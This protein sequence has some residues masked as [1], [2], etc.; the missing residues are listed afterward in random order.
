LVLLF[1]ALPGTAGE[2]VLRPADGTEVTVLLQDFAADGLSATEAAGGREVRLKLEDIMSIEFKGAKAPD[3][4]GCALLR[5]AAG[6]VIPARISVGEGGRLSASS[7]WCGDFKVG[8]GDISGLVMPEAVGEARIRSRLDEGGRSKD[9]LVLAGDQLE[10]SFEGLSADGVKFNSLLG[11]VA[12]KLSD[13]RALFFRE[14]KAA[15][16]REGVYCVAELAGGGRLLGLPGKIEGASLQ[17]KTLGGLDLMVRLDAVSLVRVANGRVLFLGDLE[18]ERVDERHLIEGLPFIWKWRRDADVFG[19]PLSLGGRKYARGLGVAAF[20]DLTYRL[21]GRYSTFK[22]DIGIC[23][24]TAGGGK[25]AF[26]VLVDGKGVFDTGSSPLSKGS[27]P[28]A[29]SVD[30]S[31]GKVLQ[32]IV[33]FGPD[34]SDLGDIGG[35]GDARLIK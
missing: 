10:G 6:D 9:L 31:G 23:D 20:T 25:T 11:R 27:L 17:W 35:W 5:T 33:D 13:V 18:P 19:G 14:I 4:A 21:D 30:V 2:A 3:A 28:K 12:F 1:C 16:P 26:R 7:P 15:A 24:G 22:A 34:G 32:L 29:V 8:T